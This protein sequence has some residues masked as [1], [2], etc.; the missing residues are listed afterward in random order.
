SRRGGGGLS[1]S[2]PQPVPCPSFSSARGQQPL[3]LVTG[4]LCGGD[5]PQLGATALLRSL[6]GVDPPFAAPL[7]PRVRPP[8]PPPT[9]PPLAAPPLPRCTPRAHVWRRGTRRSALTWFPFR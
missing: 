9:P 1:A 8:P 7:A 2:P 3:I 5:V 6:R 4:D